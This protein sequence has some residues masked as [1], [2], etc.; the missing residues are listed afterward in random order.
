MAP[1]DSSKAHAITWQ[2]Q[3]PQLTKELR[4]EKGHA[5]FNCNSY[6]TN[7]ES[8]IE[9]GCGGA[10][11]YLTQHRGRGSGICEFPARQGYSVKPCL[12]L[13]SGGE[14]YEW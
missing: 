5:S 8:V 10:H 1:E 6:Q 14:Q 13:F 12:K 3:E 11:F 7:F 9:T 2:N 4:G